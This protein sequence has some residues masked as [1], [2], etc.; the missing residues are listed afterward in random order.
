MNRVFATLVVT[1]VHFAELS[2]ENLRGTA[3]PRSREWAH[4]VEQ[5]YRHA[6]NFYFNPFYAEQ[7]LID[8]IDGEAECE[9]RSSLGPIWFDYVLVRNRALGL[10]S[11]HVHI[12]FGEFDLALEDGKSESA[13]PL[14]ELL[15]DLF[16]S[17]ERTDGRFKR[18]D[19][20]I[21]TAGDHP[22][23][24]HS[25]SLSRYSY[26]SLI[27]SVDRS[28]QAATTEQ[29]RNEAPGIYRLLFLSE[30]R[31]GA[32]FA[33]R[34]LKNRTWA[35]EG[36]FDVYFQPGGIVT[37][38]EPYPPQVRPALDAWFYPQ[39]PHAPRLPADLTPPS[40]G[41]HAWHYNYSP[42]YP[43]L[44][45]LAVPSLDFVGAVEEVLRDVHNDVQSRLASMSS[46]TLLQALRHPRLAWAYFTMPQQVAGLVRRL[47]AAENLE[48]VRLTVARELVCRLLET[49]LQ[50]STRAAVA[51][52]SQQGI[53]SSNGL[54]AFIALVISVLALAFP[55]LGEALRWIACAGV[56]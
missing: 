50:A 37:V 27:R 52:L 13:V 2:A 39:P 47:H 31:V 56:R 1:S 25:L 10:G 46:V 15:R 17:T 42:E 34:E 51:A 8:Y 30:N 35:C 49:Q 40:R 22:G 26:V 28:S 6:Y 43:A 11:I 29:R 24:R 33:E 38:A 3:A 18:L 44:R 16:W 23:R 20:M 9:A 19:R 5:R 45:F 32:E 53:S 48:A 36:F 41:D 55:I 4:F 21:D 14:V 12:H 54:V 7:V